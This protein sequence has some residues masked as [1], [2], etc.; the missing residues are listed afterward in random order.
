[1]PD[2]M[3]FTD[4]EGLVELAC[5]IRRTPTTQRHREAYRRARELATRLQLRLQ[6]MRDGK[7]RETKRLCW[8][9]I[10][11]LIPRKPTHV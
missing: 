8:A 3:T 6:S 5:C 10:A 1:M 11:P 4:D 7:V 9:M 2:R